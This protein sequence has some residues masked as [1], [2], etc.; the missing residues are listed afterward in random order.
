MPAGTVF[1][2]LGPVDLSANLTTQDYADDTTWEVTSEPWGYVDFAN[3]RI[4]VHNTDNEANNWV[5]VTEDTADYSS[6]RG[7]SIGGLDSGQNYVVVTLPDNPDTAVDES[8]YVK[9]ARTEQN[10]IDAYNWEAEFNTGT[11]PFVINLFNDPL[12]PI[13]TNNRHFDADDVVDDRITLTQTATEF[14]PF[15]LGQAVIYR[16]PG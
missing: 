1:R 2:Y 16:E 3:D 13:K 15:E 12:A 6:R 5:V 14:N 10:A 8:H 7:N 11:N 4:S 9:L